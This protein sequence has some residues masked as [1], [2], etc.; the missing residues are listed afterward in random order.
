MRR[1]LQARL[2]CCTS[3]KGIETAYD[4]CL[5]HFEQHEA[6]S[7]A[8][9]KTCLKKIDE[10]LERMVD[11]AKQQLELSWKVSGKRRKA[12]RKN[13]DDSKD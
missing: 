3:I 12:H 4:G 6:I 5:R 7:Q 2:D 1:D 8:K 13:N 10:D 11:H 9:F